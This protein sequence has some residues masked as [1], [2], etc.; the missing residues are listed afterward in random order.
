[1]FRLE[2]LLRER[3]SSITVKSASYILL[4]GVPSHISLEAVRDAIKSCH[5]VVSLHE[6][7]P[8][9]WSIWYSGRR[10]L[11]VLYGVSSFTSGN[12]PNDRSLLRFTSWSAGMSTTCRSPIRS[13]R[14][15]T[16]L[17]YTAVPSSPSL[18][19]TTTSSPRWVQHAFVENENATDSISQIRPE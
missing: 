17:A 15:C 12:C 10:R 6:V 18:V 13:E 4:Q 8:L 16:S 5:G 11:T 9:S 1:M 19:T 14:S 2:A 3:R 7:S